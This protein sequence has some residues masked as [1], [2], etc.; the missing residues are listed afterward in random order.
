MGMLYRAAALV[1]VAAAVALA[2]S[3]Q[4]GPPA[5]AVPAKK[6]LVKDTASA[7]FAAMV[8]LNERVPKQDWRYTR[9][10][11][12]YEVPKA[13]RDDH[14][15]IL[16][17][18]LNSLSRNAKVYLAARV[19]GTDDAL[20]RINT[21]DYQ[22]DLKHWDTLVETTRYYLARQ[23]RTQKIADVEE[24][25]EPVYETKNE[26]VLVP[27]G[28][29]R[30]TKQVRQTRVQTGVVKKTREVA[31]RDKQEAV[32]TVGPWI[33][34][35]VAADLIQKTQSTY[36]LM[37][38]REFL[39]ETSEDKFYT[40]F[41][42]LGKTE[43]DF[44]KVVD[45]DPE[46]VKRLQ[47]DRQ[48]AVTFSGVTLKNRRLTRLPTRATL[49]GGYFWYSTDAREDVASKN[50]LEVV[51]DRGPENFD[52]TE[53]I[54]SLANGLQ[55]YGLFNNKGERQG[56][57]PPDIAGDKASTSNDLRVRNPVSCVRCHVD[58]IIPFKSVFPQLRR[59][60]KIEAYNR[61][62]LYRLDQ[63]YGADIHDTFEFD[64][65]VYAAA[66][67]KVAG[68]DWTPARVAQLYASVYHEWDE[69]PVTVET[70][71]A[72]LGVT[73]PQATA[74]LRQSERTT[75]LSLAA[76]DPMPVARSQWK[77]LFPEAAV[78]LFNSRLKEAEKRA[79]VPF[80][81]PVK[82][83][84]RIADFEKAFPRHG[85]KAVAANDVKEDDK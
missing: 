67:K 11:S 10:L 14:I 59:S 62:D 5:K 54:A 75:L 7:S 42:G 8:D 6:I 2:A 71:A 25:D 77:A 74:V 56:E 3:G 43:A 76:D 70:A 21:Y 49:R 47:A 81:E 18:W 57:A 22:W 37:F 46:A 24:Y 29:G 66:I 31:V 12:L 78:L 50:Y 73:V 65:G 48:G 40:L 44:Y 33:E 27:D 53:Q 17:F 69:Q 51:L 85:K 38:A 68:K 34:P 26:T 19:P 84:P 45:A 1:A 15:R 36:P 83:R 9:Y 72:E 28:Y 61:D 23:L 39:D 35:G 30:Y 63:L 64:Q 58:G 13:K 41:L 82:A 20:L 80:V 4:D 60:I 32:L 79:A 55:V 16:N 52:A